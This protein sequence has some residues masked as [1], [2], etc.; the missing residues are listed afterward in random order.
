MWTW[1]LVFAPTTLRR[2]PGGMRSALKKALAKSEG[3]M[4]MP[5]CRRLALS[6]LKRVDV[7]RRRTD[8]SVADVRSGHRWRLDIRPRPVLKEFGGELNR[9]RCL[10]CPS[11]RTRFHERRH[12]S[13][14]GSRD[15]GSV[16]QFAWLSVEIRRS[17][18]RYRLR[19]RL[20]RCATHH[21]C[22]ARRATFQGAFFACDH[23]PAV[24]ETYHAYEEIDAWTVPSVNDFDP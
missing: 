18:P 19:F 9:R 24:P 3:V 12:H 23:G 4:V 2:C 10:G 8:R 7:E 17:F 5:A 6:K 11:R 15:C 13:L 22:H 16:V 20:L 1:R 14:R 21:R